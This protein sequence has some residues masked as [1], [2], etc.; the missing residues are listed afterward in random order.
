MDFVT[1]H[2]IFAFCMGILAAKWSLDLG[3]SKN[4]QIINFFAGFLMA[5]FVLAYLYFCLYRA[6]K[7]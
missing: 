7:N 5:P 3:L 4:V 6:A 2:W 1:T